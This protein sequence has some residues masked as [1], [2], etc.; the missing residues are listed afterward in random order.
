M[1]IVQT[2]CTI[3][4]VKGAGIHHPSPSTTAL[5]PP[6]SNAPLIQRRSGYRLAPVKP[7]DNSHCPVHT[8]LTRAVALAFLDGSP[9]LVRSLLS[10]RLRMMANRCC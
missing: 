7:D 1:L 10:A 8:G 2:L 9:S 6:G 5:G 3:S 4:T